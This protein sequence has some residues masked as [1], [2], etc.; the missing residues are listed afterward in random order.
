MTT[1][2]CALDEAF[3]AYFCVIL[4]DS[5]KYELYP[6]DLQETNGKM[7]LGVYC[8]LDLEKAQAMNK[9][10]LIAEFR[11]SPE[12]AMRSGA[13]EL[14][15]VREGHESWADRWRQRGY[16]GVIFQATEVCLRAE[17]IRALYR[18]EWR[19]PEVAWQGLMWLLMRM[20][21]PPLAIDGETAQTDAAWAKALERL[22]TYGDK[23]VDTTRK[24]FE[25]VWQTVEQGG[26]S[27]CAIL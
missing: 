23:Q 13:S 3:S 1:L 5:I 26:S 21:D 12:E 7:G 6:Q 9:D 17:C 4:F 20:R 16:S 8:T 10:V 22:K 19:K 15:V 18:R 11:P 25:H 24:R 27:G 2:R 14:L